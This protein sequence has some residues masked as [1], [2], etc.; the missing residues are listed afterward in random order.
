MFDSILNSHFGNN[1]E[2]S[3]LE[4]RVGLIAVSQIHIFIIMNG[5]EL[6]ESADIVGVWW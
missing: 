1:F 3:I 2:H 5:G 6:T 4:Q